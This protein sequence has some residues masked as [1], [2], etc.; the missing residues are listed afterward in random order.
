VTRRRDELRTRPVDDVSGSTAPGYGRGTTVT[1]LLRRCGKVARVATY[2]SAR[3]G[4]HVAASRLRAEKIDH[5]GS[6]PRQLRLALEELGPTFVKLGQLLSSRSDITPPEVQRELSKL[7]DHAPSIPQAKLVA[8]LE[9]SL[10]SKSSD[11]FSILEIAPVACGSIAQVHRGT[12]HNGLR[13]AVKVRRPG[14]RADIDADVWLLRILARLVARLSFRVG[15]YDPV[16]ILDEF[17][18]LL[19]AETD[20]IA[21]ADNLEAVRRTFAFDDAVAIPRVLT[22]MSDKSVLV[23]DWIE[24]IPLNNLEGLEGVGANRAGLA[25]AILH[26]YGVMIFQSDRFHADPHPGNLIA[27]E[28]ERLALIDFGEVG[29]VEPAER[30]ALLGMMA[31]VLGRDG[32]ALVGAVLSVSRTTRPVDRTEFG[33]E[34]ATLLEPVAGASLKEM[35]LGETLG[36][37]LHLLRVYGVVLPSDLAILIKTM[38]E[39]EATTNELDPTMSMLN[40]VGELGA[41]APTPERISPKTSFGDSPDHGGHQVPAVRPEAND[42]E[43]PVV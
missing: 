38:I 30:S 41:F 6:F 17:A 8:E 32:E 42:S 4:W 3:V 43:P 26:A 39:C 37:L 35:K 1:S 16:A 7:R 19:R 40:L 22:D 11:H 21:E 25:R 5:A 36:R 23:M 33:A 28:G 27:I 10:G 31:A 18:E 12:L 15:S 2:R 9:R 13:V 24:G 20:F 34:L 14:V 29:S